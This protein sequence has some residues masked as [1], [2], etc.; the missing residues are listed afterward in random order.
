M[1][2]SMR[3]TEM[4]K[5]LSHMDGDML[6]EYDGII[7]NGKLQI[8]LKISAPEDSMINVNGIK[9]VYDRGI[10]YVKI[11]LEDY[12]NIIHI[13]EKNHKVNKRITLYWL[14]NYTKNY[15]LSLDDNIWFLK[16]IARNCNKYKSIFDNP[17]LGFYKRVHDIYG[18]KIHA[19]I[20]YQTQ[21]FNLSQMPA[22]FKD[23]W[24]HNSDWLKLT[25]HALQD[26]PDRPYLSASYDQMKKD[27]ESVITE[28]KRFAGEESLSSVTTLHWGEATVEGCRALRDAGFTVL[29]GDF[30]IAEGLPPVSYY[31]DMSDREHIFKRHILKDMK[32]DIIFTR[33]T[34]I[35]DCFELENL[36]P[37]L[38]ELKN[39]PLKSAY[40]DFCIHEQYFYPEY[41]GYQSN[42]TDKVMT[43]IKW[44]Y[45]NGYQS[46][47]LKECIFK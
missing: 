21:D 41:E 9:A 4:I 25:F 7:E 15:R 37:F 43:V 14:K 11:A 24:K 28:I 12:E 33:L 35:V 5:I 2:V 19:N 30:N 45:E 6:N 31:L 17:Y 23:E 13:Y 27:C 36:V 39:N 38:D 32:E 1:E 10:F 16:D 42:Y 40:L 47:F 34:M 8:D 3:S 18:T 46:A 29:A 22:K 44:A 20:Y 26:K